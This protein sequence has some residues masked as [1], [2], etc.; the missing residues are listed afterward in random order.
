[1]S[2]DAGFDAGGTSVTITGTGFAE[3]TAVKFGSVNAEHFTIDSAT[4]ITTTTPAEGSGTVNV[5]VANPGGTSGTGTA[6]EFTFVTPGRAPTITGLSI[7]KGPAAGGSMLV[8]TGTGFEG[9]TAVKF[10]TTNANDFKVNSAG[11]ITAESPPGTTGT[12][13]VTVFT[14]NGESGVTSRDRFTYGAPTVTGLSTHTGSKGG[15]TRVIITGSGFAAGDAATA[16]KFGKASATSV[17]CTSTVECVAVSPSSA[18]AHTVQVTA[19]V[20]GKT[21]KRDP[22][23]DQFIYE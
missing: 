8:I 6:D 7:K 11:S 9:V 16:F 12:V 18:K 13:E 14:P 21:S 10:G 19:R 1:V 22:P 23:A 15:G 4:A 17:N 2:P 5:T 20:G 3:A